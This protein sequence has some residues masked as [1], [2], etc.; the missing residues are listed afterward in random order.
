MTLVEEL[1]WRGMIQDATPLAEK[2]LLENKSV[3]Y[4]GFDPTAPSLQLGNLVPIMLLLHFQKAGHTPLAIIGGATGMIGDPSGKSEERVLQSLEAIEYNLIR[5]QDQ[6]S[7]FLNFEGSNAA[8]IIN[9]YDWFKKFGFLEFLRDVGKHLSVN[10]MLA[11]DS[12]KQRL[13]T[14]LSFTEFSYQLLQGYDFLHLYK[15]HNCTFQIGGSDQW[16]NITAG[17][18]LVRRIDGGEVHALTCP[19]I[20]KADGTKF[21]KSAAGEKIW[22]DPKMTS[23]YKFYQFWINT[24]DSDALRYIK[25]FSMMD[26]EE[27]EAL[28]QR[29][30]A[31]P[32]KRELQLALAKDITTRVHSAEAFS[33]AVDASDILF[34]MGTLDRLVTLDESDLLDALEGVPRFT[35]SESELSVGIPILKLIT[36]NASVFASKGE[37]KRMIA[38]GGVFVNKQKISD[39]EK[40]INTTNLLKN[41]Y[42]LVQKGKKNYFLIVV[43]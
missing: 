24:P 7:K 29:S 20:T 3:V 34:G 15:N 8:Q 10:Y 40:C 14:G 33:K 23:P 18:E 25:V 27:I 21:G 2:T 22:L 31:A 11:K 12:V 41:R 38:N 6:L 32:E 1:R 30:L 35:L 13:D 26:K 4:V 39:S 16:G 42:I 9:N 17:I 37:A 43:E 5:F 28:E 19:L 36:E